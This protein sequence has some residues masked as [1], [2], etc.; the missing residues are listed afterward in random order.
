MFHRLF[1]HLEFRQKY[2]AARRIFES[3]LTKCSDVAM[4]RPLSCLIY[5][6]KHERQCQF[7]RHIETLRS[8]DV[9]K[10]TDQHDTSVGQRK[11]LSPR[12][13]SNPRPPEYRAGAL[14]PLSYEN[15]WRARSFNWVHMWQASCIL[16]GSAV[17]IS[18]GHG[19]DSCHVDQFTFHISLPSLK[20]TIFIH[21]SH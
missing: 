12:Q 4:K 6:M 14:Y 20:C 3:R 13:E 21:L 16:L 9:K 10:R 2:P 7:H 19:F 15:S 17:S 1:K 11:N 5:Y 18:T 8:C